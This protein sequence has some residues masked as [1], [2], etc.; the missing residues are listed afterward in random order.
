MAPLSSTNKETSKSFIDSML[1][2][3]NCGKIE[4]RFLTT[5]TELEFA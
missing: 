3:R 5:D 1:R 2:T 4:N